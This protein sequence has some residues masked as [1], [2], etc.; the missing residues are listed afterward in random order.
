M[1]YGLTSDNNSYVTMTRANTLQGL[2]SPHF[3][4]Q[5]A[6]RGRPQWRR[7]K[8]SGEK[9]A[10]ACAG[11]CAYTRMRGCGTRVPNDVC[12]HGK[13]YYLHHIQHEKHE[14][15]EKEYSSILYCSQQYYAFSTFSALTS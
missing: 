3:L 4:P 2:K 5:A 15:H 11:A 8:S 6:P 13:R 7:E 14:K 9:L 1:D 12:A 10:Q